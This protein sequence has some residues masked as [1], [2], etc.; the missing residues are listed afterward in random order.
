ME[1]FISIEDAAKSL[2]L[3]TASLI[4]KSVEDNLSLVVNMDENPS[5]LPINFHFS[6][7]KES[8]HQW[9]EGSPLNQDG[10]SML[11]NSSGIQQPTR[12]SASFYDEI[13]F[14]DDDDDDLSNRIDLNSDLEL[15]YIQIINFPNGTKAS[16]INGYMRGYWA[17]NQRYVKSC[18]SKKMF[19][20]LNF[21]HLIPYG[22]LYN[23]SFLSIR[24]LERVSNS[25]YSLYI[26]T[27]DFN[28]LYDS[29]LDGKVIKKVEITAM[30]RRVMLRKNDM[31]LNAK[32]S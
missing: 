10:H 31:Q 24:S 30:N 6:Q 23:M 4:R 13:S 21:N 1:K 26:S 8:L 32:A 2:Y 19:P 25:D 20:M 9:L 11:T 18:I 27:N 7:S 12:E 14:G 16:S 17:L 15:A 29:I 28:Y 5:R 3:D 22:V